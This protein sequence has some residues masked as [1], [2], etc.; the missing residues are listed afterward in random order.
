[1]GLF[2]SKRS[3]TPFLPSRARAQSESA[4]KRL[5]TIKPFRSYDFHALKYNRVAKGISPTKISSEDAAKYNRYMTQPVREE[6]LI[7]DLNKPRPAIKKGGQARS[8]KLI[9]WLGM[10]EPI[11][12]LNNFGKKRKKKPSVNKKKVINK[13]SKVSRKKKKN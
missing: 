7:A 6:W 13:V 8:P 11:N 4:R 10:R 5:T 2:W 3:F 9:G 12:R 1:M